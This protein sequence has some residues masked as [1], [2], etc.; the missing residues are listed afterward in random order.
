M[1]GDDFA[2]ILVGFFLALEGIV[3]AA[4]LIVWSDSVGYVAALKVVLKIDDEAFV[5]THR[6]Y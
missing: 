4:I 2:F 3:Y 5:D 1:T 6:N